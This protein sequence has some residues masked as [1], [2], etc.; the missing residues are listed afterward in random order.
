MTNQKPITYSIFQVHKA[1]E[2]VLENN[3][4]CFGMKQEEVF[5]K[6]LELMK[7]YWRW[8]E[9]P[10]TVGTLG[11]YVLF[12]EED[13]FVQA[14]VVANPA[15]GNSYDPMNGEMRYGE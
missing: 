13:E 3:P 6:I 1:A 8:P 12:F 14:E 4:A 10:N 11:F 9:K 5:D 7:E 15:L 2:F